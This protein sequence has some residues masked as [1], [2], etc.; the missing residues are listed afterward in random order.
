MVSAGGSEPSGFIVLCKSGRR[1]R[2]RWKRAQPIQEI[3]V[4]HRGATAS[5]DYAELGGADAGEPQACVRILRE[6]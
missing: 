5:A 6:D 1:W 4:E 2:K 3:A